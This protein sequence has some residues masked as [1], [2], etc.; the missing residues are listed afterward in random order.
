[1]TSTA[2]EDLTGDAAAPCCSCCCPFS[3]RKR[4][5]LHEP[6][7][8]G[9]EEPEPEPPQPDAEE[10]GLHSPRARS[11]AKVVEEILVTEK[12]YV[13]DLELLAKHFMPVL[14]A[15]IAEKQ[16]D[17]LPDCGSLLRVHQ[18]LLQRLNATGSTA[19]AV[20]AAFRTMT[21]FLRMYSSY[22][23]AYEIALQAADELRNK[24]P[25]L[26]EL[27]ATHGDRLDSLLIKPVQRLC[28]YPLF[29]SQLLQLL[30]EGHAERPELQK[31]AEAVSAI[32]AEVNGKVRGSDEAAQLLLLHQKLGGKVHD[33]L[34]PTRRLHLQADVRLASE[35][36]HQKRR[37]VLV[38]LS[39]V[40]LIARRRRALARPLARARERRAPLLW[41]K[42]VLPL[43][44]CLL[45]PAPTGG[46]E[47]QLLCS[48][49]AHVYYRCTCKSEPE[50][51]K[52]LGAFGD[53]KAA[54]AAS[55]AGNERRRSFVQEDHAAAAA[56]ATAAV[57]AEQRAAAAAERPSA[58]RERRASLPRFS[59]RQ[60]RGRRDSSAAAPPAAAGAAAAG[61]EEPLGLYGLVNSSGS[62]DGDSDSST[63]SVSSA[64][65]STTGT[66]RST[67]RS[68]VMED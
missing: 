12:A 47:L 65:S 55:R 4:S 64:R 67:A 68:S 14:Q 61:Q 16:A 35:R 37:S 7:T 42:A 36:S 53:A 15:H 26:E 56:A 66:G 33:L 57:E 34:A 25:A 43:E 59:L 9:V 18:E 50:A 3:S 58:S 60:M 19:A 45:K 46:A 54:H 17:E 48:A 39:D 51:A 49:P 8:G 23:A 10:A 29:F 2:T 22:C 6:L 38:V 5:D 13:A 24:G 11:R 62:D 20:A 1:M 32:N 63:C 27:E 44:A 21:P 31:V 28:K 40:L 52:L 30:P 41:L